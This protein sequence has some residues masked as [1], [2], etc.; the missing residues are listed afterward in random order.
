L[1]CIRKHTTRLRTKFTI[2]L[3]YLSSTSFLSLHP[4]IFLMSNVRP[5]HV[6]VGWAEMGRRTDAAGRCSKGSC[7]A[8]YN[9]Q[10]SAGSASPEEQV[11]LA[12]PTESQRT[13]NQ[14]GPKPCTVAWRWREAEKAWAW[15]GVQGWHNRLLRS[16]VWRRAR[17]TADEPR[18]RGELGVW[19]GS[20]EDWDGKNKRNCRWSK[21]KLL[22][23]NWI[24]NLPVRCNEFIDYYVAT[25]TICGSKIYTIY[26]YLLL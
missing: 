5:P 8:I 19:V 10:R 21:K 11:R 6:A 22:L 2:F 14:R 4:I 13:H 12:R 18:E 15:C 1:H 24:Y 7:Y 26:Y 16:V 20:E 17:G 9:M 25:W 3:S 23:C